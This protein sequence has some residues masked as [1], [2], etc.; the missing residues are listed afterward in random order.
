MTHTTISISTLTSDADVKV[1]ATL[2]GPNFAETKHVFDHLSHRITEMSTPL[3]P[4]EKLNL[5][6]ERMERRS[7]V[8]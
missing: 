1:E 4:A 2:T 8:R 7:R 3:T 5:H 6:Y